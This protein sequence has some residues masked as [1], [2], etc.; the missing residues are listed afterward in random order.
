MNR[1]VLGVGS[2][3]AP[4]RN[5]EQAAALLGCSQR[6]VGQSRFVR[7]A[8]IG[9]PAQPDYLNG[10]FLIETGLDRPALKAA[11]DE[12]ERRL[13]RAKAADRWGPRTIDLD[14][15]VWNGTIVH[16]DYYRRPFLARAVAEV[17]AAAPN[18]GHTRA[19]RPVTTP[20]L[21]ESSAIVK[22]F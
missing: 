16:A 1:V 9:N 2:N 11:L 7:T 13:G 15:V 14:I 22:G 10:A 5:I 3:I 12:V 17:L 21:R 20:I 4:R 8:P 19:Q 18:G 6:V